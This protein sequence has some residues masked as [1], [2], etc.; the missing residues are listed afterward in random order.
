MKFAGHDRLLLQFAP[1]LWTPAARFSK[2]FG[3]PFE[4]SGKA[5]HALKTVVDHTRKYQVLASLANRLYPTLAD[6]IAELHENGFTPASRS[7][8]FAAV[9]E[10]LICELYSVLDGVRDTLYWLFEKERGVQKKSTEK[11]FSLAKAEQYGEGFPE[12]I[13]AT[14]AEAYDSWFPE[15]RVLRTT[16]THGALGSCH[17]YP[18]TQ[19]V[20][21]FNNSIGGERRIDD[22]IA[23]TSEFAA[24]VFA[25][26]NLIFGELYARLDPVESR[27]I[28]GI[29]KSRIY[30]R[31]VAP[32]AELRWD[33]G[34]C[35]SRQWFDSEPD[36]RCPVAAECA[37]YAQPAPPAQTGA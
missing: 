18:D 5:R 27:H 11:L 12:T 31:F 9:F 36:R 30:S 22:V 21:Y 3:P 2:F 7:S 16:F 25:L 28:C 13:R 35:E 23:K 15:L 29:Y 14:L 20:S 19:R 24:A 6:D 8:E 26:Q 4:T 10:T 34:R 1:H 32:L 17:Y 37:A 33:S